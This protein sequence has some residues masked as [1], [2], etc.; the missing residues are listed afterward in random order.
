MSLTSHLK[1][2]HSPVRQFLD[3]HFPNARAIVAG[4]REKLVGATTLRPAAPVAWSTVG[5][6]LDYRARYYFG[7]T[8]PEE[9]VAW[10][11]A[12]QC[13]HGVVARS[14]RGVARGLVFDAT[15]GEVTA[16]W[17]SAE[18]EPL[19]ELD[20]RSRAEFEEMKR[21]FTALSRA[22]EEIDPVGRRLDGLQE[23]HLNR[24]CYVLAL[25]EELFRAGTQI[26]SPLFALPKRG[27]DELLAVPPAHA[28]DDLCTLSW[29]F[30]TRFEGLLSRPAVLNPTFDGSLDVGG[31]DADLILDGCL[32]DIKATVKPRVDPLWLY[33]LL[34]YVLLDYTDRYRISEVAIYLAR[35]QVTLR[36][37]LD[38]F[39]ASM[40]GG[41]VPAL[42]EVRAR[43]Q[44]VASTAS[45]LMLAQR[46]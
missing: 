28:I 14:A 44:G 16:R 42:G 17:V 29:A 12:W 11:G 25:F 30:Y 45:A 41:D 32:I 23:A 7:V 37:P 21:F 15:T 26:D 1:T 31:A 34:G 43:F 13:A 46:Q 36:W 39:L 19:P 35:Q 22:V 2:P 27:V 24:Y 3:A 5:T 38:G 40:A 18:G 6:A 10:K 8:P 4:C 20:E 33:Q 9:F